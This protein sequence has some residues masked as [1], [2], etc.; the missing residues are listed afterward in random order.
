MP[1]QKVVD[2]WSSYESVILFYIS[3]NL[4]FEEKG[5]FMS[6]FQNSLKYDVIK[7]EEKTMIILK[8]V[9]L[10]VETCFIQ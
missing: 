3:N 10:N 6:T 7:N 8:E 2:G 1:E 9:G 5:K 4:K